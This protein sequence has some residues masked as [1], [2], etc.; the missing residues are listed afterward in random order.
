MPTREARRA[1]DGGI[2][3][4]VALRAGQFW[5]FIDQRDIDKHLIAWATFYIT[6]FLLNW[7]LNFVWVYPDKP[8]LEVAAIVAAVLMPWTPVQGAVI[9]WYF[10]ARTHS[11][12]TP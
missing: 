5:D 11:Q 2:L 6:Y 9:K 7:V 4:K 12:E 3:C 8:G 10:A 1:G